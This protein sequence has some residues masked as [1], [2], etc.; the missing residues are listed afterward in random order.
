MMDR[1][2][3]FSSTLLLCDM[4][5]ELHPVLTGH[6]RW[7]EELGIEK[8]ARSTAGQ[9]RNSE[10]NLRPMVEIEEFP[11]PPLGRTGWPWTSKF[12]RT[13]VSYKTKGLTWPAITVITPSFNQGQYLEETIRSVLLQGYPRLQYIVIDG[14]STDGS[15]EIIR[16]Y[17]DKIA[18]WV[19]EKDGGQAHAINKGLARATGDIIAY[20]NSDDYYLDGT[21]SRVA[22]LFNRRPDLDLFHGRCRIVDQ[23]GSKV[24]QRVGSIKRYDEILDLW[25]V[26]WK[27]RNF[28]Q[29]E[30]FWTR[31]IGEKVGSFREDLHLVMDY[32]YWL[33][34]LSAGGKVGF[35]DAELSAF[36]MQPNQKSA[37]PARTAE[38]LLQV[39]HPRIF[40]SVGGLTPRKRLAL[41][42]KWIFHTKF[43]KEVEQ[44]LERREGRWRRLLRLAWFS[45]VNPRVLMARG[46]WERASG[47]RPF[48]NKTT[49]QS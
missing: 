40:G 43:L 35:T 25:D 48:V 15:V 8:V 17:Q 31:R 39:V 19:S 6:R 14:G 28:V 18:F 37:Q 9:R 11:S 12:E 34:I 3:L 36:R 24:D 42:A 21:L 1:K 46:Y 13:L 33:R 10:R 29:P 27:R 23:Y 47:I 32:E 22:D 38:E 4:R 45:A 2:R 16:K 26:W 49:A 20:L 44:S 41:Q 30:V 5:S 7:P